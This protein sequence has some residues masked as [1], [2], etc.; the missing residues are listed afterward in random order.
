MG[1]VQTL[2][3]GLA[4]LDAFSHL[5]IF[6][7]RTMSPEEFAR[8]DTVFADAES[9]NRKLKLLWWGAG[10]AEEGIRDGVKN[11][12]AELAAKGVKWVFVEIPGT[13]HE[14]Q[15][16]RKCLYDFAP[17]IFRD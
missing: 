1:A 14:W 7:R 2:Y 15:T 5:G 8:F 6:S 17:R 4:N 10:T 11:N 16:W 9:L 3:V 12:L 13:S